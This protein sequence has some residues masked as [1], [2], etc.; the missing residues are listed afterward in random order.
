[1]QYP[2]L[3]LH[4]AFG[5]LCDV[6]AAVGLL[7]TE[8]LV[9]SAVGGNVVVVVPSTPEE[10]LGDAVSEPCPPVHAE[11]ADAGAGEGI[12]HPPPEEETGHL[13]SFLTVCTAEGYL[14]PT[15]SL[16]CGS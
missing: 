5:G 2:I 13:R 9:V 15:T 16:L 1:M 3:S 4:I 7:E 10:E 8:S 11:G 14:T 12:V 6:P